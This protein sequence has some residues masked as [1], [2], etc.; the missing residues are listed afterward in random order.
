MIKYD[1]DYQVWHGLT[2][3]VAY[4]AAPVALIAQENKPMS[5]WTAIKGDASK[6]FG[7][8]SSPKAQAVIKVG[9]NVVEDVFPGATGV[10]NIINAFAN[11]AIKTE[12]IAEAAGQA[13]GTGTQKA[14]IVLQTVT[15]EILAFAQ[16][17]GL[18]TP[19]AAT[20]AQVNTAI[21]TALNLL[22]AAT[23]ATTTTAPTA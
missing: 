4:A 12:G 9:E 18:P 8:L 3:P 6:L 5:F 19:T 11:E 2:K 15:P 21:V 17:Y 14:V 22:T 7:W 23:P 16:Q 10:V 20:L 13:A 1:P